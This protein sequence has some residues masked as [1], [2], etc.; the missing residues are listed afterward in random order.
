MLFI[1]NPCF[2]CKLGFLMEVQSSNP[3]VLLSKEKMNKYTTQ[4]SQCMVKGH[5][6]NEVHS[7]DGDAV[8]QG[9]DGMSVCQVIQ[10]ILRISFALRC[11]FFIYLLIPAG[12]CIRSKAQQRSTAFSNLQSAEDFRIYCLLVPL[13]ALDDNKVHHV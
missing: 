2:Q 9:N 10:V 13:N 3:D 12:A 4:T 11:P 6:L 7:R 8:S 1:R 5:I